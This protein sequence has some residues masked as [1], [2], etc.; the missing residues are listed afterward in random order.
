MSS[1]NATKLLKIIRVHIVAGGVLAFSLGALLAL[2]S[3][4]SFNPALVVS[5][6][7]VMLLGDLS[8]HYSNDYFDVEVDRHIKQKKFFAGSA[9]LVNH[10]NL[11]P[12]SK[13]ISIG[14]LIC[15]NILAVSIFLFLGAPIEIFIVILGASL[16]GWFYSAPPLRL[17]SRGFG[18]F[19]VACVSGFAI[20]GL[21]YLAVRGQFDPLFVYLAV[22]F[23]MYGFMLSLS[24]EAPDAEIDQK[25]GKRN[26]VVRK[27]ERKVFLFIL[28]LTTS[29]TSTFLTYKW[30]ITSVVLDFGVLALFSIVPLTSA[31]FGFTRVLQKQ[32]ANRFSTLNIASLFVFNMLTVAYLIVIMFQS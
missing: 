5:A 25:G 32:S 6:Y 24:L 4:G 14:L 7:G 23:V 18:E 28:A 21:G 26:F 22:P 10:P 17:S 15:A 19:A 12:L 1:S 2:T 9:V 16:V 29:A 20:P 11:R 31:F 30:L 13:A 3:G 8:S 27:G